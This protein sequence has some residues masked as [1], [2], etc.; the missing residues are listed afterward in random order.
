MTHLR[1]LSLGAGVQSSTVALMMEKG[2]MAEILTRLEKSL[3]LL[4]YSLKGFMDL[5]YFKEA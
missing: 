2:L 5:Q 1:I 4:G 3:H